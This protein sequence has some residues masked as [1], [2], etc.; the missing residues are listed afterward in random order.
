MYAGR[1]AYCPLVSRG[2]YADWT[3]RHGQTDGRQTVTLRFPP[4][5][6]NPVS[7][8]VLRWRT[9]VVKLAVWYLQRGQTGQYFQTLTKNR[10][11]SCSLPSVTHA[12]IAVKRF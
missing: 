7:E 1:V 10:T 6:A 3:E 11:I 8:R 2:E 4:G 9:Y 12:V 5:V